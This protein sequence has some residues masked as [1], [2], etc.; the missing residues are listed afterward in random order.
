MFPVLTAVTPSIGAQTILAP[1][2]PQHALSP[3]DSQVDLGPRRKRTT[4][5]P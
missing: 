1:L 2:R 3:C 5:V 4:P